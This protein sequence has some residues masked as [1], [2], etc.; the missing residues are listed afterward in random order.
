M[1]LLALAAIGFHPAD[2]N[3]AN[4][5]DHE[6]E[7]DR[8]VK[9]A[10]VDQST[11]VAAGLVIAYGHALRPP[12][13]FK[14]A[15]S[16]LFV[17]GV[18]LVPSPIAAEDDEKVRVLVKDDR[19]KLL[20]ELERVQAR[21]KEMFEARRSHEEILQYVKSQP[22]VV[23]DAKW[24][25]ERVMVFRLAGDK[26]FMHMLQFQGLTQKTKK[27]AQGTV[28]PQE[29]QKRLIDQYERDLAS[30]VCLFFSSDN[31]VMRI[32]DPRAKVVEIMEKGSL[33]KEDRERAM[34]EV[35]PMNRIAAYDVLAN[36]MAGEWA[37]KRK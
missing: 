13:R 35:F 37:Q 6:R 25:G 16:T 26:H 3:A 31:G 33:S 30:G 8:R 32:A 1:G 34:L 17:N 20:R 22:S 10:P 36:Y 23:A 5:R 9:I 21:A 24:E 14:Y 15:G 4:L 7:R 19:R 12:Y 29:V 18:Q 2:G 27:Q 28:D 11:G